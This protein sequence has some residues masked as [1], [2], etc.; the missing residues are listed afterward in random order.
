MKRKN[1]LW[2][3]YTLIQNSCKKIV[4]SY[5]PIIEG[6]LLIKE[7]AD[8]LNGYLPEFYLT[9]HLPLMPCKLPTRTRTITS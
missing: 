5:G 2:L 8:I 6:M 7:K 1:I 9:A 3:L 4:I